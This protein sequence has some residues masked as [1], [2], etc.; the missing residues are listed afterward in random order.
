MGHDSS[1]DLAAQIGQT[2]LS[3]ALS[4]HGGLNWHFREDRDFVLPNF[5]H[6]TAG[7]GYFLATLYEATG[8][9]DFLDGALG[10]ATY[11][12]AIARTENGSFLVP[13]G[14]PNPEWEGIH[15]IG[16]AHGAAGTARLFYQLHQITGEAQWMD[17]VNASAQGIRQSGVPG[18]PQPGYGVEP[19]KPDLRFGT[20]SAA[21]FF[22][23]RYQETGDSADLDFA[24]TLTDALLAR[25]IATDATLH[26]AAPRYAFFE[27]GGEPAAFTGYFYG[28]A[29]YGLLLLRL[30]AAE[31]GEAYKSALPDDPFRI[32][33]A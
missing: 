8:E 11:L 24:R 12:Q 30:D 16:W 20:A 32:E 31:R 33:G 14:W 28:A 25:A 4:E 17:L 2:L 21:L 23:D 9:Q 29:G 15:E 26:W 5:S 22:L 13:Y 10:T 19:F 27:H 7:I 3:R 1:R 18:T 6:G